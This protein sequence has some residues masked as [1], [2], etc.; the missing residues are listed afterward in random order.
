MHSGDGAS[1]IRATA[2][3]FIV[4]ST[5]GMAAAFAFLSM[6]GLD[7][8]VLDSQAP[9]FVDPAG[10]RTSLYTNPFVA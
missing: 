8:A 10:T 5:H 4:G 2:Q 6:L 3:P 7:L 1:K 9:I